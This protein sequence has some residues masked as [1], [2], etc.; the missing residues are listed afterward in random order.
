VSKSKHRHWSDQFDGIARELS[1]LAIA[2]DIEMFKPGTAERILQND[3]SVC[4]RR[5]L[6]AFKKI[7][8]HLMALF[9]LEESAIR[10]LGAEDTQEI[11]DEVRASI[12]RLRDA[13]TATGE[14]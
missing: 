10:R 8:M 9:P 4:G 6:D 5:N 3:E 11:L 14:G 1:K 7:R 12:K 2:C 13:G